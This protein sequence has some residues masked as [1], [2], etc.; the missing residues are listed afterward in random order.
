MKTYLL[1]HAIRTA[2]R[3]EWSAA[4]MY[5]RLFLAQFRPSFL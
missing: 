5:W 3:F 2:L 4:L 1:R